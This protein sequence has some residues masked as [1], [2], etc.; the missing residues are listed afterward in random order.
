MESNNSEI[1][2]R[3]IPEVENENSH[4]N[5]CSKCVHVK[6][7]G[8]FEAFSSV[9]QEMEKKY[10]YVKKPFPAESLAVTCTEFKPLILED[11][12][13]AKIQEFGV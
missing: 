2:T 7:C 9:L 10:D 4:L 11:G 13:K 8:A 3:E 6:T 5:S 1:Q 12:Q